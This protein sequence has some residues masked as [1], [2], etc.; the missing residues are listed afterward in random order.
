MTGQEAELRGGPGAHPG[1][2]QWEHRGPGG[3]DRGPRGPPWEVG[4][5]QGRSLR[6]RASPRVVGK[7]SLKEKQTVM[8]VSVKGS[9]G[10]G[11][12]EPVRPLTFSE[13][14]GSR[15][16]Q[17]RVGRGGSPHA[18][19]GGSVGNTGMGGDRPQGTSGRACDRSRKLRS[20][21]RT[22]KSR[23]RPSSLGR[24]HRAPCTAVGGLGRFLRTFESRAPH[25]SEWEMLESLS[26]R[27]AT[28]PGLRNPCRWPSRDAAL[29]SPASVPHHIAVDHI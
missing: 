3:R 18:V 13:R 4:P 28:R 22:V 8:G 29:Q 25:G 5:R 21:R 12:L 23:G 14:E 1:L 2:I 7:A 19:L 26:S 27:V 24:K 16:G 20:L 15:A 17:R 10:M 9:F 11:D 6:W